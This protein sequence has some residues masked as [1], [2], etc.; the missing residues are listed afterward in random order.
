MTM[1]SGRT[2]LLP[3]GL[4]AILILLLASGSRSKPPGRANDLSGRVCL[5]RIQD[6][7]RRMPAGGVRYLPTGEH[8]PD[9]AW[10]FVGITGTTRSLKWLRAEFELVQVYFRQAGPDWA[11]ELRQWDGRE[12][13]YVWVAH[14]VHTPDERYLSPN[15]T[16]LSA[17]RDMRS[18][19][20]GK[21]RV[22][23]AAGGPFVTPQGFDCTGFEFTPFCQVEQSFLPGASGVFVNS[24]YAHEDPLNGFLFWDVRVDET[25]D[26]CQP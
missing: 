7:L 26:L 20:P 24:G 8:S 19:Q 11:G 6:K 1:S 23:V 10:N 14:A 12:I 13:A 15:G 5:A 22:T 9:P 4:L 21:Y 25:L 17:P 18:S 2:L 16:S 3:G